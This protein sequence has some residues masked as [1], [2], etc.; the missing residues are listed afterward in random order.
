MKKVI[1]STSNI[2]T[3]TEMSKYYL[4]EVKKAINRLEAA[5]SNV[6]SDTYNNLDLQ[7]LEDEMYEASRRIGDYLDK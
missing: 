4:K 7:L 3:G 1:K 6:D 5:L 2:K